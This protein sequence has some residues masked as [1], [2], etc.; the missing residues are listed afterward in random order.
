MSG[1]QTDRNTDRQTSEKHNLLDG[2]NKPTEHN[3]DTLTCDVVFYCYTSARQENVAVRVA[4][5]VQ[6]NLLS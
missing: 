4:T 2:G 6:L 5:H 1:S 3:V